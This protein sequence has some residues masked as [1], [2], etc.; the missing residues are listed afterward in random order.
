M[1]WYIFTAVT[2]MFLMALDIFGNGK[3]IFQN[4]G[5]SVLFKVFVLG[6]L[7]HTQL[8]NIWIIIFIIFLSG[9]TSHAPA[10]FRYYSIF[11]GKEI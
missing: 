3:W 4:R 1:P 8:L 6:I 9:I 5:A 10:K 7:T 11:H 2:G